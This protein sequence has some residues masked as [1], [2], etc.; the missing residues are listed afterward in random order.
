[1]K[2]QQNMLI[3]LSMVILTGTVISSVVNQMN[4][5]QRQR[6]AT[7][8]ATSTPIR[9]GGGGIPVVDMSSFKSS[10]GGGIPVIDMAALK[11]AMEAAAEQ[12]A[13]GTTA[14]QNSRAV[15]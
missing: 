12:Q 8:F 14:E 15:R 9:S 3:I 10:S 11:Q 7:Q 13:L 5:I 6:S 2:R 1:M 4:T